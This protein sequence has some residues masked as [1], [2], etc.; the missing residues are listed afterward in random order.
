V[1]N[2][3]L[4]GIIPALVTP[5]REDERMDCST[6]QVLIDTLI[7]SG[8]DGLFVNGSSGEFCTMDLEERTVA[9]RFCRQAIAGRVPLIANVGCITTRAT[10]EHA[11]Q[12]QSIGV[13]A[14]AVIT[15]YYIRP[16][17][18]E[19]ADHLIDVCRAVRVPVLAYNFPH[20]GGV[21]LETETLTAVAAKA[22]NLAGVKD[23]SG[24][25]E[26]A[27]AYRAAVTDREFA[28]FTGGEHIVLAALEAGCAGT[29]NAAGNIAPKVF[30]DLYRAW[31]EGRKSDA[32][33][34]QALGTEMAAALGLH[35]FPSVVKEALEM[36]GIPVGPCRKPIGRLPDESRR[37]LA[38]LIEHLR[39]EGM[40]PV[41]AGGVS[42]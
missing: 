10:I 29:V 2:H 17:Q 31:R 33:R 12:A 40:L 27:I 1:P 13:D 4:H 21:E 39:V 5:L 23:S 34:L 16:S 19:L 26:R 9:L 36:A 35:T 24:F 32:E 42:A 18:Q 25:L 6:L 11:L 3:A 14:I 22:P 38:A 28:V 7:A 20:H 37:K 41:K 30:V 8:V 15:P